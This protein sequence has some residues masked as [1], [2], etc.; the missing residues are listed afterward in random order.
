MNIGSRY[1]Q[2]LGREPTVSELRRLERIRNAFHLRDDDALWAVFMSLEVYLEQFER[3]VKSS[4]YVVRKEVRTELRSWRARL[5][6][7]ASDERLALL[8]GVFFAYS[9]LLGG[10]GIIIGSE[11]SR[12]GRLIVEA[13]PD[14]KFSVLTTALNRVLGAP[15]SWTVAFALAVPF[16]YGL[17]STVQR[18]TDRSLSWRA[19][20]KSSLAAALLCSAALIWILLTL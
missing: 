10:L 7:A 8:L 17:F 13:P 6:S 18:S 2:V 19:R 5:G 9:S 20:I 11:L 4:Q 15:T 12:S 16:L 1:A 14:S 3:N